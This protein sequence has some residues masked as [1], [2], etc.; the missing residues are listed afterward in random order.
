MDMHVTDTQSTTPKSL[1]A[2]R[3][4]ALLQMQKM[5]PFHKHFF[6]M[7]VKWKST[8]AQG[9]SLPTCKVIALQTCHRLTP[10]I[11]GSCNFQDMEMYTISGST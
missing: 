5:D 7:T 3:L 9:Q 4:E 8:K 2:D 11:L 6:K 10:K 1:T